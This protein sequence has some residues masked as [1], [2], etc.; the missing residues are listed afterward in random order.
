M[1][2]I[3]YDAG[4]AAY[5]LLTGRWSR[6]YIPAL[7]VEAGVGGGH[8]ILDV[9]TGTG[10]VGVFAASLVGPSGR[11]VGVDVSRP[12][13]AVAAAKIAGWPISL[14]EMDAQA[15]G[16]RDES[17]DAVVCQ[18]GLMFMPDAAGALREWTRVLRAG[19]RL[20]VCVYATP[21]RV[22]LY[23]ILMDE[24]S[25]RLPDQRDVLYQPSA[26][27]DAGLL[28]RLLA[29]AGL[30]AVRVIEETRVHRF[31]SFDEYWRPF[32]AGGGRHGQLY[33]RLAVAARREVE[34]AV[35]DRMGRFGVAGRLEIPADVFMAVGER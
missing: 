8:R 4:A 3:S 15:L 7:L 20:A 16:F 31:A 19:S 33:T 13:L 17:F 10:E 25:R 11:V 34:A 5:D 24:L 12:M 14:L 27:A 28:E 35:R 29:Q 22:P 6:L 2:V 9:A 23:G 26:L 21:D 1:R 32:R 18:L 30:K